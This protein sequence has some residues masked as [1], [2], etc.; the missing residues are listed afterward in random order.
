MDTLKY[1]LYTVGMF[2]CITGTFHLYPQGQVNS[3]MNKEFARYARVFPFA[4]FGYTPD[5]VDY[6]FVIGISQLIA[7]VLILWGPLKAKQASGVILLVQMVGAVWTL[8]QL[9][10]QLQSI[11]F[12]ICC[13]IGLSVLLINRGSKMKLD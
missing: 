3:T 12:P 1:L 2:Y 13:G 5:P 11:L 8:S 4:S 7:G 9:G 10:E 6:R